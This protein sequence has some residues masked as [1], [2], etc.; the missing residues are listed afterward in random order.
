MGNYDEQS[1]TGQQGERRASKR[2]NEQTT[3]TPCMGMQNTTEDDDG[4][5]NGADLKKI[6][7]QVVTK[8]SFSLV[9]V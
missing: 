5:V 6:W 8:A 7:I 1:G 9:L 4:N 3:A 2:T